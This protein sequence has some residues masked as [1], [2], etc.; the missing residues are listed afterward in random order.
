MFSLSYSVFSCFSVPMCCL[1][2]GTEDSLDNILF[3]GH[4]YAY[5]FMIDALLIVFD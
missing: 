1:L 4:A 5:S 2:K 3:T